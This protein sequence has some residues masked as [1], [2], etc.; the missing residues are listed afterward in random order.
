[1]LAELQRCFR[2]NRVL[3]TQHARR[4]MRDDPCGRILE[5][6]VSEAVLTGEIIEDYPDDTPYPSCLVFGRTRPGRPIHVVCAHVPEEDRAVIITVYEPDSDR[7]IE[8][9]RR[10]P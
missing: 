6:E 9:R 10:S 1:M 3:Y 4:E 7:W 8:L 2:E 5:Q